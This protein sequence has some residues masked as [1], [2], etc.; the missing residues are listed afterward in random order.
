M[1]SPANYSTNWVFTNMVSGGSIGNATNYLGNVRY[2][3]YSFITNAIFYDWREGWSTVN[4]KGKTVQAVQ[5]DIVKFNTWLTSTATN[6]GFSYNSQCA[7]HKTHGIDS[8]YVYNNI[9]L[10]TTTLPAVRIVKGIQLPS[11]FTLATSFPLYVL[12]D[13]NAQIDA[14]HQALGLYYPSSPTATRYTYPA[15][16]MADAVTILSDGW[17]DTHTG[18]NPAPSDTTVN[19]AMLEGIVPSN[20]SVSPY[21]SGGV[22]NFMRLLENWGGTLTYNGSIIVMFDSQYATNIW[23]NAGGSTSANYYNA[24]TRH[25]S[26]DLNYTK[27]QNY[28]PPLTPE[29]RTLVRVQWMAQ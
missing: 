12:G 25:W 21:Y 10:S 23:R 20:P 26:F 3:G 8:M 2:A 16:L 15:A 19:A 11:A 17:D 4:S 28:L 24:P 6:T 5:I 7:S 13:Y 18:K 1:K 9:P 22:E 27:G 29:N 14:T